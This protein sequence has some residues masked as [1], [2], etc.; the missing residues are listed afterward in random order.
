[1]DKSSE[2]CLN[3][4]ACVLSEKLIGLENMLRVGDDFL[5]LSDYDW[6]KIGC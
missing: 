5:I 4:G 3:A 1:M 2:E 6:L